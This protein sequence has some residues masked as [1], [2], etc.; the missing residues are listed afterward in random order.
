MLYSVSPFDASTPEGVFSRILSFNGSLTFPAEPPVSAS[1]RDLISRFIAPPET[2]LGA[3]GGLD[4]VMTHAFFEG[5]QWGELQYSEP[6]FLPELDSPLDIGYF[7]SATS[8]GVE[9]YTQQS[10]N[11]DSASVSSS[12]LTAA[13]GGG[14]E[15]YNDSKLWNDFDW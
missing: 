6:P 10:A 13:S 9:R 2:R 7:P 5:V 4:E 1:A 12:S 14:A 15:A 3:R 8:D 11:F